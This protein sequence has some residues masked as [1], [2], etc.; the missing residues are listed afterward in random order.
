MYNNVKSL[1]ESCPDIGTDNINS[2]QQTYKIVKPPALECCGTPPD[3]R[4]KR[5]ERRRLE[6][7]K[8]KK[9]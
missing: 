5:R 1:T 4:E 9:K 3:G 7:L 2:L 6:R 8:N